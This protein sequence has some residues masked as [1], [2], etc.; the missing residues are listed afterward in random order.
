MGFL[1]P[2]LLAF[3]LI[4][5]L[6]AS[7]SIYNTFAI[8]VAQRTRE[9]AMLRAIGAGRGQT[10][11]AVLAEALLVGLVA[12]A[13]GLGLGIGVAALLG[14]LFGSMGMDLGGGLSL[15]AGT[16]AGSLVAGTVITVL[17][18]L[19]PAVR[20][21]RVRPMA[22]LQEVAT[23]RSG[24]STGRVV[25]GA[26]LAATGAALVAT[27]TLGDAGM[28][29]AAAGVGMIVV[30]LS[31]LGPVVAGP[32]GRVLGAP[33]RLRGVTGD[34]ARRNAVRNPRR[35]ASSSS[36]LMIG[37]AVVTLFT[38]LGSSLKASLDD[39]VDRSFG[40]DLVG[41]GRP[42][43][44]GGVGPRRV[45]RPGR[46][47][48]RPAPRP[49]LRHAR[50]VDRHRGDGHRQHAVAVDLRTHPR[51]RSPALG[52]P[53]PPPDPVHGPSGGD[54]GGPL[55]DRPRNRG[56]RVGAWALV[57][58]SDT[59][60][61]SVFAVP[62]GQLAVVLVLG[63]VAGVLAALRPA[64]RAARLDPLQAIATA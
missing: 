14:T 10:L 31:V 2:A 64:A 41:G 51:A 23:D 39:V 59:G 7:F 22:A 63:A 30:A 37:V 36:A 18:A 11:R 43:H 55:R 40:G 24:A 45:H 16:L 28:G 53:A 29:P 5:L 48:D 34:L 35:T 19:G 54:G 26:L 4:A 44:R 20:A 3:A 60:E 46:R 50:P 32:V 1:R 27:G 62:G 38:V 15:P 12:S 33:L 9:A 21:S 6:V 47:P 25:T 8:I 61:L 49:R 57:S 52:R 13:V 56:R 58:A 17:C 42:A